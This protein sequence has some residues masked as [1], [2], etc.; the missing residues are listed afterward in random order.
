MIQKDSY[1]LKR[2]EQDELNIEYLFEKY[3]SYLCLIS[4]G[5]VKDRD[6]AKDLV[7]E[8]FVSCWKRKE[9]IIIETN[10]KGYAVKAVKNLCLQ[11]L[12]KIR[13]E[14][15]FLNNL[16]MEGND[17]E[18]ESDVDVPIQNILEVV[19]KLPQDRK[20]IFLSY[21]FNQQSYS[22]IAEENG[23]SI[24]T[25]KTQM[26]RAYRFIRSEISK[27]GITAVTSAF[28]LYLLNS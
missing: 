4:F 20:N 7:Q 10:F 18:K 21:V 8:F 26:K 9:R 15:E 11:H 27:E 17:L 16:P 14:T 2:K 13:K 22:D 1:P 23:I 6:I 19:N 3:Y 25:V 28:F 5:I 12:N 24:N